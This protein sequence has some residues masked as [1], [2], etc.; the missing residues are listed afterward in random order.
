[1]GGAYDEN[2]LTRLISD[3]TALSCLEAPRTKAR[4]LDM[5]GELISLKNPY[6]DNK[7]NSVIISCLCLLSTDEQH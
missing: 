6:S 1:M 3:G 5:V 7:N 2:Y 4:H